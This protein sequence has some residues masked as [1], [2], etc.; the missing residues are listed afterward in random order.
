MEGLALPGSLWV[1]LNWD[2]YSGSI[3][4][5]RTP[6]IASQFERDLSLQAR[7]EHWMPLLILCF[8]VSS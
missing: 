8:I 3:K 7:E 1:I 2:C 4:H 6:L 5:K